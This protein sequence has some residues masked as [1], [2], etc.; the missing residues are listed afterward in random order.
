MTTFQDGPAKGQ[1]LMLSRAVMFLRVVELAGKFDALDQP[2]DKPAGGE[3]I[4][5]YEI[6][7]TPRMCHIRASGGR[8]GFYPIVEYRFIQEQ[9]ADA[10]MRT[11]ERWR[12]WVMQRVEGKKP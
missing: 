5:A 10:D 6:A 8:G 3:K 7:S 1:S 12:A 11:T 2:D 4:Y 9:P